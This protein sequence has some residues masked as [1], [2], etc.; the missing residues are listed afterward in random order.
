MKQKTRRLSIKAKILLPTSVIILLV[1]MALGLQAYNSIHDGMVT[2][3]VEEAQMAAK[4]AMSVADG[5]LIEKLKPGCEDTEDYQKVLSS[6]RDVQ[7]NYNILYLYTV[8]AEGTNLYY[9]VDTDKSE[10][11]AEV[12]KAFEE[13]Y[14]MLKGVFAGEAFV[15]D[16]ID[17]SE[18]GD[19]IS[20]YEPIR[21]S[22]G[23][24]V[25]ILGCDYDAAG[26]IQLLN[27]SARQ[28]LRI[29]ITCL[30]IALIILGLVVSRICKG[31]RRVDAKLYDLVHNEGDLTRELDIHSGDELELIANNVNSLL[32]HI[33]NIMLHIADNSAH[34]IRSSE[35]MVK[36][37]SGAETGI[38]DVSAA[39]EEMS[40]AMEETSASINQVNTSIENVYET[41]ERISH[42]ANKGMEASNE[43][44]SKAEDIQSNAIGQ[45]ESAR[46]QAQKMAEA[47][48]EKIE[49]SRAVEKI[50]RLTEDILNI[51]SQTNLLALNA[52]IEAARAGEAGR[53]FAVVADEIGKLASNSAETA[54]EIQQV[55]IQVVGSVNELAQKAEDMLSFIDEIA[56]GGYEKLLETTQS[57]RDDV[58][59]MNTMMTNFARES[60]EVMN[61]VERIR[62][63]ASSV[64]IAVEETV[65]GVT[66]VTETAVDLTGNVKDIQDEAAANREIADQ[67]NM[68]V[69][70]FKLQ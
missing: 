39:M 50:D 45:R 15:Q 56:M 35:H 38:T 14:D 61:S 8:Y 31:L 52:S 24:V 60:E 10:L 54:T 28:V 6:L 55:S 36:N 37:I 59:D 48:N 2:M 68:E 9:G 43:I 53:G 47:M 19:V 34:L 41:I 69:N 11:Q 46:I 58:G 22:D 67:L 44:M 65:K 26:V 32:Q 17:Y 27:S 7:E 21:N 30:I 23:K 66:S 29:T 20:V 16:Y 3:G 4:I 25:A 49:Q 64:N 5:D 13:S 70:K 63:A 51:T 12:G 1:C 57:Y 42:T 40:A 62:E 33:R 18:Y